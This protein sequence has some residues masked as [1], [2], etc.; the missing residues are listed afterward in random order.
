MSF[1]V[2]LVGGPSDGLQMRCET[3]QDLI[4]H[5][6]TD[7]KYTARQSPPVMRMHQPSLIL[8]PVCIPVWMYD[9]TPKEQV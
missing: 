9:Y 4:W 2:E 3:L 7:A 8:P 6:S 1:V 5:P